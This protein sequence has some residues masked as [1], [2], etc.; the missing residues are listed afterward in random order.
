MVSTKNIG[1]IA[2]I[3]LV[4]TACTAIKKETPVQETNIS[5]AKLKQSLKF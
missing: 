2:F 1:I 4:L 3:A 5:A